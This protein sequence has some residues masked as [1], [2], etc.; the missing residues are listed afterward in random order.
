[1]AAFQ[2]LPILSQ[3]RQNKRSEE[4]ASVQLG[5]STPA[6][7]PPQDIDSS[8]LSPRDQT[9]F[10]RQTTE[11]N[12]LPLQAQ[13]QIGDKRN[14]YWASI[15]AIGIIVMGPGEAGHPWRTEP[16]DLDNI[17][18]A[19]SE[20]MDPNTQ[21]TESDLVAMPQGCFMPV[22]GPDY[23]P[24]AY[25]NTPLHKSLKEGHHD[26]A[27]LLLDHGA[28]INQ[29]NAAGRTVVHEAVHL[30]DKAG[31]AFLVRRGAN[32]NHPS[33]RRALRDTKWNEDIVGVAG[34]L[35][36]HHAIHI[37][38]LETLR[39]LV[40]H[41]ADVNL[42][43]TEGWT[44]LDLALLERQDDMVRL[45]LEAG[46]RWPDVASSDES[47]NA[48]EGTCPKPAAEAAREL[49]A[50]ATNG[51]HGSCDSGHGHFPPS[52]SR[53]I[54]RRLLS[55]T[56]HLH[57][58]DGL[59]RCPNGQPSALT[60]SFF[61]AL[62]KAADLHITAGPADG[63]YCCKCLE[64]QQLFSPSVYPRE[65][66]DPIHSYDMDDLTNTAQKECP[67]CIILLDALGSR[68]SVLGSGR[69]LLS[70]YFEPD[71]CGRIAVTDGYISG[72]LNM[73]SLRDGLMADI[74]MHDDTVLGTGSPRTLQMA[75][76][77]LRDCS[78]NHQVC[79]H[80]VQ[81]DSPLPTRV[82]DVGDSKC[83]PYL[84]Q[85]NGLSAI[86]AALS[87]CWGSSRGL[88]TTKSS[89]PKHC[90]ALPMDSLPPTLQQA[91]NTTMQLGL[92][93]IWI[94]ALCIVQD[95]P[96]DWER[97]AAQMQ[98][99]YST[100]VVTI[101]AAASSDASEGLFRPRGYNAPLRPPVRL[102]VR[103]PR[104]LRSHSTHVRHWY[105][106]PSN[107]KNFLPEP[108]PVDKRGWTLQE[109]EMSMRLLH[110]DQ[111]V[112]HW[113][114][115]KSS[116]SEAD[117][118]GMS[119]EY[120]KFHKA[121]ARRYAIQRWDSVGISSELY[122]TWEG[123]VAEYTKRTI[124]HCSDRV[125]AILGL[126]MRIAPA[127]RCQPIAGIWRGQLA[128]RSLSWAAQSSK[129]VANPCY[130]SWSWAST[131]AE[132]G[133][134][135]LE[136]HNIRG[137]PQD[138]L[139]EVIDI[140]ARAS[141]CQNYV[142]GV[143]KLR[144]ILG[145]FEHTGDV[146]YGYGQ[147]PNVR[148]F[149]IKTDDDAHEGPAGQDLAPDSTKKMSV[150][151]LRKIQRKAARHMPTPSKE[152]IGS[153]YSDRTDDILINCHFLEIV[154]YGRPPPPPRVGPP[155]HSIWL[156]GFVLCLCLRVVDLDSRRFRRVGI[157]KVEEKYIQGREETITIE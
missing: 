78:K 146:G 75:R 65:T 3:P 74:N 73:I 87:Y 96:D 133:Y 57:R 122:E 126:A 68:R 130:P 70:C 15:L 51:I 18:A 124:S 39:V 119:F 50:F 67:L 103:V 71:G 40:Q 155:G 94:D 9:P 26:A 59:E 43:T 152:R 1:M 120:K 99:I 149:I 47:V 37:D 98:N 118:E 58:Q 6:P 141:A 49:L 27:A 125:P 101:A 142:D 110:F 107:A 35:P 11:P 41:G 85:S 13:E 38:S 123:L 22:R 156:N 84:F 144:G 61:G 10:N 34:L 131:T 136:E 23:M 147:G 31:I 102:H 64:F 21:W 153:Y 106:L 127:L 114:C 112:L 45:L 42:P 55:S 52:D 12:K 56:N 77:W 4:V 88:T 97:E 100:A 148:E 105:V 5:Y 81:E 28:N 83:Q 2:E 54:Y 117:P 86:F 82:I 25:W 138:W 14:R 139:T 60:S 17:R 95:D 104:L 66:Y 154:K 33:E 115:L 108:G 140:E 89:L 135:L 53:A 72:I 63:G 129:G 32:L 7:P 137:R 134:F 46:A 90:A 111:G 151:K 69:I 150:K 128:I 24:W 109:R 145:C 121:R 79:R 16:C 29:I 76:N 116:G 132:T 36:I 48:K 44:A 8:S 93:Y 80:R 30:E 92:R 113:S 20:G 62:L 19:L 157:C 91:I 143:V